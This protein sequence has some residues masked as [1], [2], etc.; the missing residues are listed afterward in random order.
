MEC[1]DVPSVVSTVDEIVK[2]RL[3]M[4]VNDPTFFLSHRLPV[5][6]AAKNQYDVHIAT[7]PGQG[8]ESIQ[9]HGFTHHELPLKRSG[10]NLV[11]ELVLLKHLWSLYRRVE[12]QLCHHVTIKPVLYGSLVSKFSRRHA[13]VNAIPGLGFIYT[14]ST[15]KHKALKFLVSRLY[16]IALSG[17]QTFTIFQNP[18]NFNYFAE[19]HL[20]HPDQAVMIKGS[21]IDLQEFS[22]SEPSSA[23][24]LIVM[25]PARMLWDKGVGEFVATAK[26]IRQQRQDIVFQL[27][28][29]SDPGNPSCIPP[30][31]LQAWQAEGAVKWLGHQEHMLP[32]FQKA[33]VICL[34]SY[35]EG[36]P[37]ALIEACAVGRPIV[38]TDVPGCRE[39]VTEGVNG[40]LVPAKS[41][42]ALIAPICRLADDSALRE[43]M[44]RESRRLAEQEFSIEAVVAQH[45]A[46]YERALNAK[47]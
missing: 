7:G 34:P 18:D 13:L 43:R 15:F 26:A 12:P 35:L 17:R 14:G 27:I 24:P 44:G 22:Y 2:P 32:Y 16:K 5:A 19:H 39:T 46:L 10:T 45:L 20:I 9:S 11:S 21:G 23:S 28:G 41:S 38:T 29:D 30:S 4:V 1:P 25:L 3:L 37:K 6:L 47:N 33:H 36:L 8:I 42:E 40:F 31:Q